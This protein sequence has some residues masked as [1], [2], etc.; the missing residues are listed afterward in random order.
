MNRV[1]LTD[2]KC[3][4]LAIGYEHISGFN[5]LVRECVWELYNQDCKF[6]GD[7]LRTNPNVHRLLR[8]TIRQISARSSTHCCARTTTG[9]RISICGRSVIV[10]RSNLLSLDATAPASLVF[11]PSVETMTVAMT[12]KEQC[13]PHFRFFQVPNFLVTVPK[14]HHTPTAPAKPH[15]SAGL[16]RSWR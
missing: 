8:S 5:V 2:E 13:R 4:R 15:Y 10:Q 14:K 11:C 12:K 6:L 16:S 7:T 3:C 1:E 9:C